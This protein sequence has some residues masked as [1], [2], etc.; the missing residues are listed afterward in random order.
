MSDLIRTFEER[1]QRVVMQERLLSVKT[2]EMIHAF[3]D[4]MS[5][6]TCSSL[7]AADRHYC[8]EITRAVFGRR[9][10]EILE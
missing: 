7:G 6:I 5:A 9:M 3:E 8:R 2:V 4:T 10:T 1:A